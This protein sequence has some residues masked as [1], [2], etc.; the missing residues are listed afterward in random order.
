MPTIASRGTRHKAPRL[1]SGAFYGVSAGDRNADTTFTGP[2]VSE[3]L[4]GGVVR[5][6]H[7]RMFPR[8]LWQM[9]EEN[10]FSRVYLGVHWLFDAFALGTNNKPNLAQDT[11]GVPLGLKI[12]EDIFAA[13]ADKAP[14]KSPVGPRS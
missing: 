5:P 11:G 8:E 12:A 10:G 6:Q 7:V 14:K 1:S 13:G 4:N 3:E 9:I 2:F